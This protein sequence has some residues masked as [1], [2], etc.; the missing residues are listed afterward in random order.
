MYHNHAAQEQ[1][2]DLKLCIF[3]MKHKADTHSK[4][5]THSNDRLGLYLK[6]TH[7]P[8]PPLQYMTSHETQE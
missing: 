3:A 1:E 5:L 7:H 6:L 4:H 2:N 8:P